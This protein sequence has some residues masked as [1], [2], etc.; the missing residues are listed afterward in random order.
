MS[1]E[2]DKIKDRRYYFNFLVGGISLYSFTQMCKYQIQAYKQKKAI[3]QAEKAKTYTPEQLLMKIKERT[4]NLMDI[5]KLRG[6]SYSNSNKTEIS[7]R[8]FL[9]GVIKCD[10][11]IYSNN[12]Y[13]NNL[14]FVN[15]GLIYSIKYDEDKYSLDPIDNTKKEYKLSHFPINATFQKV[16]GFTIQEQNGS[17]D[18]YVPVTDELDMTRALQLIGQRDKLITATLGQR[19]LGFIILI[20]KIIVDLF[21]GTASPLS[22]SIR[23]I[24]LGITEKEIGIKVD[25]ITSVY[26]QIFFNM[27]TGKFRF[28][29]PDALVNDKNQYIFNMKQNLLDSRFFRNFFGVIFL[30]TMV[31]FSRRAYIY[32]KNNFQN[33][34][35]K[36][37]E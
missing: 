4:N 14:E 17:I 16:K 5:S 29:L 28:E 7:G 9:N 11:P 37:E 22:R 19:F 34:K 24:R 31:Y 3:I 23:G 2:S 33:V 35:Q 25:S 36:Q 12:S 32:W 20:V 21:C 10:K 13:G 26:G 6:F 15:K 30:G 18:C 8:V 27:E 1:T